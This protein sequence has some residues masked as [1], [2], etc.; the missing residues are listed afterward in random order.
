MASER[1][2]IGEKYVYK[3]LCVQPTIKKT[4][5]TNPEAQYEAF[6][7]IFADIMYASYPPQL[8]DTSLMSTYELLCYKY[9]IILVDLSGGSVANLK[10][11]MREYNI[12]PSSKVIFFNP[13]G[14]THYIA[15][16]NGNKLNPYD[17]YQVKG[18]QGFCQTFAFFL[19]TSD[20][21]DFIVVDQNSKI[22]EDNFNKLALN[23]QMCATKIF[24][25]LDNDLDIMGKF[26]EQFNSIYNNPKLRKK[27]GIKVG[28]TCE[29]YLHDFRWINNDLNSVK[30][31]IYDLPLEGWPE[32][33]SRDELWFS[34]NFDKKEYEHMQMSKKRSLETQKSKTNKRTKT[35]RTST[36]ATVG[37]GKKKKQTKQKKKRGGGPKKSNYKKNDKQLA[38]KK[39]IKKVEENKNKKDKIFSKLPNSLIIDIIKMAEDKR[40]AEKNAKQL[41]E[42]EDRKKAARKKYEDEYR[43]LESEAG[44]LYLDDEPVNDDGG[45]LYDEIY[46]SNP[47]DSDSDDY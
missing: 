32:K 23:T 16:I 26:K 33:G 4:K 11:K 19:A 22:D 34:Y 42:L 6:Q 13:T 8:I 12:V 35:K 1:E 36:M 3:S 18:S 9:N 20:T 40:K 37:S 38:D 10:K 41:A 24:N 43:K 47:G 31:Y 14:T 7:S 17:Y 29:Q 21:D 39:A 30:D 28:T 44:E 25:I 2:D 27:Y 15:Y 45:D 46:M 5:K